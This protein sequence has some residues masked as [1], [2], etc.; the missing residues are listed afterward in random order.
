[1]TQQEAVA[2]VETWIHDHSRF[3]AHVVKALP[4]GQGEWIVQA[5]CSEVI[6]EQKVR[7]DG[8]VDTPQIID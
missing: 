5:E 2:L 4:Q 3:A 1:M 6:W 7:E 8:S